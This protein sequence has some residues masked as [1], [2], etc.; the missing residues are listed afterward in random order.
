MVDSPVPQLQDAGNAPR[1]QA[2]QLLPVMR[3]LADENRL[4]L[5][6]TLADGPASNKDLQD[7]T[8]LSQALVSHHIAALRDAGMI[9][10]SAQGRSN[11]YSICCEQLATP[12]HSLAHLASLIPEATEACC[13]TPSD[14]IGTDMRS[15]AEPTA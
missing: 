8:G 11:V 3:A 12:V 9:T 6:L 7:S 14:P 2:Q 5:L 10:V 1:E 13:L 4:T 15:S